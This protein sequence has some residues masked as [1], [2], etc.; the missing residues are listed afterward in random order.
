MDEQQTRALFVN[1]IGLM[2]KMSFALNSHET[3]IKSLEQDETQENLAAFMELMPL[4]DSL[5]AQVDTPLG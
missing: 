3:R 1:M 5:A 2:R 4:V